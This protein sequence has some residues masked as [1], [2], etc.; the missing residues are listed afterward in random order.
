MPFSDYI[1][2]FDESGSPSLEADKDDYPVFVLASVLIEKTHYAQKVVPALQ[3]L[4][5]GYFGHDQVIFHERDIRRQSG[6]FVVLRGQPELREAF[7]SDVTKLVS[8]FDFSLATTVIDKKKLAAKYPSPK[9]PYE[10]ALLFTIEHLALCLRDEKQTGKTVHV[11]A[12]ARGQP[13]DA[14]LEL[15]FRRITDGQPPMHSNQSQLIQ[16]FDWKILFVDKKSNSSGLQLADL[17]ARPVGLHHLK[18][19][20]RNRAYDAI[21]DKVAWWIK[22]FP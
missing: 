6:E 13:E 19:E 15:V 16:K 5:F 12:E 4:K 17:I 22:S 2:Y 21:K 10:I 3:A 18:P 7:L 9:S 20:Q 11:I 14:E 1:V 8:S